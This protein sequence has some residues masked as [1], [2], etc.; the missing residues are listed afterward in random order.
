LKN[1]AADALEVEH[2]GVT[3]GH[4]Y[5]ELDAQCSVLRQPRTAELSCCNKSRRNHA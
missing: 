1:T 2:E 4:V 5:S 3:I